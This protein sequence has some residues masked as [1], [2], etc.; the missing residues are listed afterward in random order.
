[1]RDDNT[2]CNEM[3][4]R[5]NQLGADEASSYAANAF[6]TELFNSLSTIISE[7]E[8]HANAQASGL[9]S[10]RQSTRSKEAARVELECD[11]N[12]ITRTARSMYVTMPGLEQKFRSARDLKD[13]DLLTTARIF[14]ADAQPLKAE[15][16]KRGLP[17][18]FLDDLND[19]IEAFEE[20][21]L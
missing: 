15:F 5:V 13:Q 10:A 7:I 19:D 2:R 12:A 4:L 3:F 16:I 9:T 11:L 14:A 18:S 17:A 6:I 1:M 21:L 20:A 8:T